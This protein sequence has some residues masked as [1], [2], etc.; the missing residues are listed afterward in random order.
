MMSQW[1]KSATA[2]LLAA[3]I[4][5]A[6]LDALVLL[7]DVTGKNRAHLLAHPELE[8]TTEQQNTLQTLLERR[9]QH[10]PLAY[11]R[12]KT[13]F[14]GREFTV[15]QQV[16]VPRSESESLLEL[17]SEYGDVGSVIDVGTGSGALAISAKIDHPAADVYGLD[18]DANC[19]AIARKNAAM[20]HAAATFL[21]S[22]LLRGLKPNVLQ[23]PIAVLANL[24]YVPLKYPINEAD[25]H[26]P[27]LALFSGRDGL[28]L[29]RELLDQLTAYENQTVILITECLESQ[30]TALKGIVMD[31]GFTFAT[32]KGLAQAFTRLP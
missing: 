12:G 32:A 10:E 18:I 20:H 13:E 22:D 14:Y 6:R 16:L 23:S 1:L 30:L 25:Q 8:I 21:E 17:L 15:N 9:L 5:T 19:L 28:D 29:Y 27:T 26:E 7:E 31:H 24:P 4:E 3:G 2:Q 11:I